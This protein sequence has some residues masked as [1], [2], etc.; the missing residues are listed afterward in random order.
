MARSSPLQRTGVDSSA[1]QLHS[2]RC[3]PASRQFG[4]QNGERI[5]FLPVE[6]AGTQIRRAFAPAEA[7]ALNRKDN[8]TTRDVN[9]CISA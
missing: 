4:H 6:Q 1:D 2:R 8:L 5:D 3:R 7:A 9:T